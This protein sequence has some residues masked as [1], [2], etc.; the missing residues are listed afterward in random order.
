[1]DTG[2]VAAAAEGAEGVAAEEEGA[3][4]EG[5][6]ALGA[7]DS[8]VATPAGMPLMRYS[9]ARSRLP[10][11]ANRARRTSAS[12]SNPISF[13]SETSLSLYRGGPAGAEGGAAAAAEGC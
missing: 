2:V 12:L 7:A 10:K 1:M 13:N 4:E 6:A 9:A 5:G 3:A 8:E 11:A